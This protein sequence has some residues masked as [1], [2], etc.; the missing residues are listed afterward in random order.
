MST[1][2]KCALITGAGSGIGFETAVLL[3]EAGCER[4][5]VSCRDDARAKE[6]CGALA[7]QTRRDVFVP[8]GI[9][10]AD[11]ASVR[12]AAKALVSSPRIDLL[13]LNAGV[14]PGA[15][16]IHTRDGLE[17][18][19]AASLGGHHAL[20]MLLLRS[21]LL[22]P[23]ARIV[24]AGSEGA[25]GD[26]PG[27]KPLDLVA[28][29]K[30]HFAGD[31]QRAMHSVMTMQAPAKHHWSTTYCTAKAL[32]ALWAQAMRERLP[33]GMAVYAV[34]PGNVPTTRAARNQP[35]LFRSMMKLA[36]VVG[37]AMGMATSASVG[38]Q[39]YL[40]AAASG[41][42]SGSFL[43]SPAGK[44][45]GPLTRQELPQLTS[46]SAAEACWRAL[47]AL[48]SEDAAPSATQG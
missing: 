28:F 31:L 39:R 8:L 18:T 14:L 42:A 15:G 25:R 12:T 38:A 4:V 3:A 19:V 33:R 26:A 46:A 41:A 43:A 35:W 36:G 34:S 27:M 20:T 24:I 9:D 37:P 22:A 48:T 44:L 32:V 29:A 13:V 11:L 45:I 10:V 40:D 21:G 47:A 17:V 1:S 5:V 16:L 7:Q 2:V 30:A 23:H 6:A